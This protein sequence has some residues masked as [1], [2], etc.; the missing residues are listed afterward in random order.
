MAPT[1]DMQQYVVFISTVLYAVLCT[2][3]HPEIH[4]IRSFT[5]CTT[6]H[7]HLRWP[8]CTVVTKVALNHYYWLLQL[9][10]ISSNPDK[11]CNTKMQQRNKR[12]KK[13]SKKNLMMPFWNIW[14]KQWPF[15]NVCRTYCAFSWWVSWSL[16]APFLYC[17]A[18]SFLATLV[19][20]H[21]TP[22]SEWVSGWA[23]FRTSVASRLASLSFFSF[24]KPY[25]PF[26]FVAFSS[27]R[28]RSGARR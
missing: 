12:C 9:Q 1:A 3:P 8:F 26:I 6:C 19:A 21:F 17:I 5:H 18:L 2:S 23:E 11:F 13:S 27:G 7:I 28:R 25:L 15:D 14:R 4:P 10:C 16:S 20:L 24:S 22:V